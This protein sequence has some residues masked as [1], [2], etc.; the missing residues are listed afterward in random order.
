MW[1]QGESAIARAEETNR[2]YATC[3]GLPEPDE[4]WQVATTEVGLVHEMACASM[5][6]VLCSLCRQGTHCCRHSKDDEDPP[7][8]CVCKIN[9]TPMRTL[10]SATRTFQESSAFDRKHCFWISNCPC[11]AQAVALYYPMCDLQPFS[12]AIHSGRFRGSHNV[13]AI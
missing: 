8:R 1:L 6:T 12:Q 5:T 7:N 4:S 11:G 9:P 3:Q 10:P 2:W 13:I